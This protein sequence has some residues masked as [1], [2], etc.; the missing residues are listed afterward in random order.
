MQMKYSYEI[1]KRFNNNDIASRNRTKYV[2]NFILP[3][4]FH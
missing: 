1:F 4:R 2:K 3:V